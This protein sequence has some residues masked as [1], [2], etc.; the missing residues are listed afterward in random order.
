MSD[1]WPKGA[2]HP[3]ASEPELPLTEW[4]KATKKQKQ[5]VQWSLC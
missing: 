1:N 5:S 3:A 4:K 2:A